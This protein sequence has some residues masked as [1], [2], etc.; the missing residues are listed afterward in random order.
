MTEY[1]IKKDDIKKT[2]RDILQA[3]R[4]KKLKN[5]YTFIPTVQAIWLWDFK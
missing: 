4:V 3:I 2:W 1:K 5:L